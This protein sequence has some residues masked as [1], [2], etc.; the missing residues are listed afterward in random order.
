MS[1]T[2]HPNTIQPKN[3]SGQKNIY[4]LL[5]EAVTSDNEETQHGGLVTIHAL[6]VTRIVIDPGNC[7][8]TSEQQKLILAADNC[9]PGL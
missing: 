1:Y 6:L 9:L 4:D 5:E 8:Y 3:K 2:D 7:G